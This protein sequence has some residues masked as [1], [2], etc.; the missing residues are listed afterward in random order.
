MH[1][2]RCGVGKAPASKVGRLRNQA[3]TESVRPDGVATPN[4]YERRYEHVP[5]SDKGPKTA[6][7]ENY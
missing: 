3:T 2:G 5:T 6:F 1:V 7:A 4:R